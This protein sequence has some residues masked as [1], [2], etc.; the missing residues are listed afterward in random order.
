MAW[1]E[2]PARHQYWSYGVGRVPI[3]VWGL[4]YSRRLA[5]TH[6][7]ALSAHAG[8][9][10]WIDPAH[11]KRSPLDGRDFIIAGARLVLV[12]ARRKKRDQ[13]TAVLE[14]SGEKSN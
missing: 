10:G 11:R 3:C 1:D 5:G 9:R 14:Q 7:S 2:T 6:V 13:V 12:L 4:R 8:R